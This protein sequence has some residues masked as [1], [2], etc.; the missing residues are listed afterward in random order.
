MMLT[1]LFGNS[2]IEKILFFLIKNDTAYPSQISRR[3]ELPIYSFQKAFDHLEKGRIVVSQQV[4][5][6]RIYRFN[7]QYPMLHELRSFL[8]STYE[9]LPDEVKQKHY[10]PSVRKRPRRRGKPL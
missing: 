6:T 3:F 1:S 7:P 4:G 2:V 5:R 8:T 9:F 10:E